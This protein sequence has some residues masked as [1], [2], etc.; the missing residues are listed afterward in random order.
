M[1]NIKSAKK[2]VKVNQKKNLRNKMVKKQ[3]RTDFKEFNAA[4]EAKDLETA[5]TAYSQATSAVDKAVSKGV[6][7]KATANRYKS[8]MALR[9]QKIEA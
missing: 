6:Y 1:P 8:R 4:I 5:N 9:M 7:K 3:V 2:R